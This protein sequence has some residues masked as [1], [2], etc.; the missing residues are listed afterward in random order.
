MRKFL[1]LGSIDDSVI[2][3]AISSPTG[4]F[5]E[6]SCTL[7]IKFKKIEDFATSKGNACKVAGLVISQLRET[8]LCKRMD[9][10][11]A[12]IFADPQPIEHL[13]V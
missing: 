4:R 7:F 6:I 2:M 10:F 9:F 1:L 11:P 12:Q 5:L 13:Y 3:Y 8:F